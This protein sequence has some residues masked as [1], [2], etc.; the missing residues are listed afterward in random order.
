MKKSTKHI[1]YIVTQG[2]FGGAQHYIFDLISSLQNEYEISLIIGGEKK[3]DLEERLEIYNIS[4]HRLPSLV[5][6]ISPLRD[7]RTLF[8][9]RRIF[10]RISPDLIHLNSSKVGILGSIAAVQSKYKTVYTVHGWVFLEP[11]S[12][13]RKNMYL[14]LEKITAR[15]KD[16][17]ILLSKKEQSI[18]VEKLHIAQ[19]KVHLV[20]NGISQKQETSPTNNLITAQ[21][22]AD[23]KNGTRVFVT[24]ANFYATKGIDLLLAAATKTKTTNF[25]IYI[26]GD[27]KDADLYR[28]FIS[29]FDLSDKVVLL[30]QIPHAHQLLAHADA[31][32]IPSRKEGLP[33]VL[34]EALRARCPVIATTVGAIP[35]VLAQ[36]PGTQL[37][38]PQDVSALACAIDLWTETPPTQMP[39]LADEYLLE[40]MIKKTK[41]VYTSLIGK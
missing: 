19:S 2:E 15:M 1:L 12:W 17:F 5:R 7:I 41:E 39:H 20:S 27:G 26:V 18:A 33:Y 28:T 29:T 11:L 24:I 40:T 13:I 16:A 36:M 6:S 21:M 38:E 31:M 30:G 10:Q 9:L 37:V 8:A 34:L 4:I 25:K 35:E 14:F 23:K 32:I 3:S 22:D